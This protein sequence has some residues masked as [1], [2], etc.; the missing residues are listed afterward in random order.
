MAGKTVSALLSGFNASFGGE[1][2]RTTVT[3]ISYDS[4]NVQPGDLFVAV[5]GQHVDGHDYIEDALRRG[6]TACI[7][8]RPLDH[9]A[10]GVC[11]VHCNDPRAALS[12]A[13]HRFYDSPS[14]TLYVIGVTG[15]DGKSSTV[16]FIHQLLQL[17]GFR[18]G[19]LSTV[20]T[21]VGSR[22]EKNPFRQSTPEA[23]EIHRFMAKM[24]ESDTTYAVL[25]ATSHGLSEKTGRLRD[26]RFA[27]GVFT[28]ISHE[29]LD[30]HGSFEQYRSDKANLFRALPPGDHG[31]VGFV[32]RADPSWTYFRDAS[33]APVR[34]YGLDCPD[35][36]VRAELLDA[37][38]EGSRIAV[39]AGDRREE[40]VLPMPGG[41]QVEN[42]L[43]A[44]TAVSGTTGTPLEEVL[45]A[46]PSLRTLPGRMTT[47][48]D[49]AP[50]RVIVDYAHTPGSFEKLFP[51]VRRFAEGRV[52][53]LF[54]SAG[55]RDVEKRR[56]QGS[57]AAQYCDELYL[58]DED[59]RDEDRMAIIE[60]IA[61]GAA[62]SGRFLRD[63]NLF[64]I[65]DRRSAI[66]A[67][68]AAARPGDTVLL[69]GKGHES[70]IIYPDGPMAWDEIREAAEAV[71]ALGH[72][73]AH[74]AGTTV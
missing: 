23:P 29:H 10:R 21:Q 28:N 27:A 52:V 8:S 45:R 22:M 18:S 11:Y 63:R 66:R 26:V 41:F 70:S 2:A 44:V 6:A 65:P 67:A 47:I 54:G 50:F 15:T 30:F 5:P 57:I 55:E 40:T 34:T 56:I 37:D 38:L 17:L 71:T 39:F 64:C 20:A 51:F 12:V 59:P 53:A 69:L 61:A 33:Q 72:S 19:F 36:A 31:G 62:E 4:R 48:T 16:F 42:V 7:H 13:S 35:A 74:L 32:N 25:E 60:G 73:S 1:A 9:H 46:V 43:A 14:D 68:V 24:V 3:G 49:R 58:T